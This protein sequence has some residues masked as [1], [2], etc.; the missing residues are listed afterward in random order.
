MINQGLWGLA[1]FILDEPG[2]VTKS[3]RYVYIYICIY[4]STPYRA[5]FL[6]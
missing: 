5:P 1:P 3:N 2:V 6:R 4:M